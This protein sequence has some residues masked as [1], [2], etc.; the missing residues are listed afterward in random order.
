MTEETETTETE[1]KA[2]SAPR[3]IE[4]GRFVGMTVD[5]VDRVHLLC[6]GRK[7]IEAGSVI[8]MKMAN[9]VTYSGEVVDTV[10]AD[11]ETC[12]EFKDGVEPV[13]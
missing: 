9:G 2:E 1:P 6:P 13:T 11:G 12:V 4:G 10:F 3:T 7:K 8:Q 5:S